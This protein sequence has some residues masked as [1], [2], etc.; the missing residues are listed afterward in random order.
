MVQKFTSTRNAHQEKIKTWV[1]DVQIW[2]DIDYGSAGEQRVSSAQE[3]AKQPVSVTVRASA[4][5]RAIHPQKRRLAFDGLI[6]DIEGARPGN[7]RNREII[8][9]ATAEKV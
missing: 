4:Y 6:W 3:Q 9:T 2:A 7:D 8:L 5:T 1:D